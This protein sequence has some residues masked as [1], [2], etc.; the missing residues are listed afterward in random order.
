[1]YVYK[2]P[3]DPGT[4]RVPGGR[5]GG[6]GE[7]GGHL[8]HVDGEDVAAVRADVDVAPQPHVVVLP[9]HAVEA[10]LAEVA[11]RERRVVLAYTTH[12]GRITLISV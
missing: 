7:G 4:S 8:R 5:G 11:Q 2:V 9:L 12:M 1:M 3:C 10:E 6:E